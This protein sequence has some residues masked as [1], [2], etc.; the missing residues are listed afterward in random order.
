LDIS[1]KPQQ[2]FKELQNSLWGLIGIFQNF[3]T[4]RFQ[5]Q[6]TPELTLGADRYISKL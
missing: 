4:L 2:E 1:K 3:E 5:I 6:R